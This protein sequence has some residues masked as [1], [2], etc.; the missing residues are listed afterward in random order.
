MLVLQLLSTSRVHRASLRQLSRSMRAASPRPPLVW[1]QTLTCICICIVMCR[2]ST[3]ALR[4]IPKHHGPWLA[5]RDALE[6]QLHA[7][8]AASRA[9][10]QTLTATE[11]R[12]PK[13]QASTPCVPVH[14]THDAGG[15]A[16]TAGLSW[17]VRDARPGGLNSTT[18]S[19]S[20]PGCLR[21]ASNTSR[22]TRMKGVRDVPC[23]VRN[24]VRPPHVGGG[25]VR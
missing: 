12:T 7:C 22:G 16:V 5:A 11:A 20:V 24:A 3:N 13:K 15:V 19:S 17:S 8:A 4:W 9:M 2:K 18:T 1:A 6:L 10:A 14:P 21:A 25:E 23:A